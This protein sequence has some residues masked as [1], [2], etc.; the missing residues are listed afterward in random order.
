M[1]LHCYVLWCIVLLNIQTTQANI[2]STVAP[3]ETGIAL[4]PVSNVTATLQCGIGCAINAV[5][6]SYVFMLIA[7]L[8]VNMQPNGRSEVPRDPPSLYSA[9]IR[10][11]RPF[12]FRSLEVRDR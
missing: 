4:V 10:S 5:Y 1:A 6:H 12:R 2:L 9:L 11:L 8:A 7:H 3:L